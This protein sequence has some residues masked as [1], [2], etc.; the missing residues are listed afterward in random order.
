M[1]DKGDFQRLRKAFVE[2]D[3]QRE[4]VIKQSREIVRLSKQVIYA[5]HRNDLQDAA[6]LMEAMK[7]QVKKLQELT[8]HDVADFGS[9]KV[10]MQEYAEAACFY[11]FVTKG[12]IPKSTE[13]N[14]DAEY[15]LLGL[16][17]LSGELVRKAVNAAIQEKYDEARK[18]KDFLS[19]L[20]GEL[21]Q[22]DFRNGELRK[23]FDGV[24][25]DL[26]KVEDLV[27]QLK[28]HGH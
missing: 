20:Y 19:E 4:E 18:I 6:K 24:K 1:I 14:L 23:K 5:T 10:A 8:K 28:S 15:Y 7:R 25:Y 3:L 13:L 26:K 27:F 16:C 11:A 22:F 2:C 9:F 21:L 17:D 12:A